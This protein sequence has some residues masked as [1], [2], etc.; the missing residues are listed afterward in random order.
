MFV[1]ERLRTEH[2]VQIFLNFGNSTPHRCLYLHWKTKRENC[3][4]MYQYQRKEDI[5]M[6]CALAPSVSHRENKSRNHSNTKHCSENSKK[7]THNPILKAPKS[8]RKYSQRINRV[9]HPDLPERKKI[10][11]ALWILH[12]PVG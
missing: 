12:M 4:E 9:T 1:Q 8:Y 2:K 6:L 3:E 5:L 11:P 7:A 10:F